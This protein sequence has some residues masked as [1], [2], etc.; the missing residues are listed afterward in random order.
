MK[1]VIM[2]S[3][4]S[5]RIHVKSKHSL[6]RLHLLVFSA[7]T[8]KSTQKAIEN[9]K[10]YMTN[11]RPVLE[12]LAYT[13]GARREHLSYRA[14]CIAGGRANL[15][16]SSPKKST[17]PPSVV[18]TFTGQ[19]A[20]WMGM[21]KELIEDYSSFRDNIKRMDDSL[22][23]LPQRPLWKIESMLPSAAQKA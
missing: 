12:S 21:A 13:L 22:A 2:D 4:S 17:S 8:Q 14:F 7:N 20:Q 16:F 1:Q 6:S 5:F 3:A 19:G 9:Y 11:N 10:E 18:F 15:D 23:L